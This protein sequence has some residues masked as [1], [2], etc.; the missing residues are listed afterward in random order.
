MGRLAKIFRL[1]SNRNRK[2]ERAE[3]AI[4]DGRLVVRKLQLAFESQDLKHQARK[5][6]Y[7]LY[8]A[9]AAKAKQLAT[10]T[11][12]LTRLWAEQLLLTNSAAQSVKRTAWFSPSARFSFLRLPRASRSLKSNFRRKGYRFAIRKLKRFDLLRPYKRP[13]FMLLRPRYG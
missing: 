11:P 7:K 6:S 4:S 12:E 10:K 3:M 8:V 1:R 9:R 13:I 2:Q 5:L